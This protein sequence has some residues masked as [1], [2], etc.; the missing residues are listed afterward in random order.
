MVVELPGPTPLRRRALLKSLAFAGAATALAACAPAAPAAPT[1]A[2]AAKAAEAP[3][4]AAPA[5]TTAPA[6]AAPTTAPT[7]APKPTDAPKPTEAP[8]PTAAAAAKPAAGVTTVTHWTWTDNPTQQKDYE[9]VL[10]KFNEQNTSVQVKYDF[11]P[12]GIETRQKVLTSFA[13]GGAPDNS[14]LSESWLA[15][16]YDGKIIDPCEDRIKAWDKGKE[17]YENVLEMSRILPKNPV[18]YVPNRVLVD[19]LYYRKDWFDQAGLKPPDTY[20][21]V[22]AAG[23]KLAKPGERA[24]FAMRGGDS[25]GTGQLNS[26]IYGNGAKIV[27]ETGKVDHDSPEAIAACEFFIS[28]YTKSKI[29]QD[30]AP[31]DKYPQLFAAFE[32]GKVAMLHHGLH[33]WETQQK[34]LGDKVAA[35]LIPKGKLKRFVGAGGHG[36]CMY[37]SSKQKDAS[38][39]IS[40]YLATAEGAKMFVDWGAAP[41]NK[42]LAELPAFKTNDFYKVALAS[43]PSWGASPTWWKYWPKYF[44][45]WPP[46]FQRALKGEITGEQ[47]AKTMAKILREG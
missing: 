11:L 17:L 36:T 42:L 13:A 46:N 22:L 27:D 43:Q 44:D 5:A 20:D 23:L 15:E 25:N 16:F 2:P 47:F 21:D 4:A 41:A 9:T 32:A 1:A 37:S 34:A 10:K 31:S 24:G 28:W 26:L 45:N 6:A 30:S 8:K 29:C 3:K 38:W 19:M 12:T 14:Q 7:A 18:L 39:L 40:S 33:S 35:T